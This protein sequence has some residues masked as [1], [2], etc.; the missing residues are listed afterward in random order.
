MLA[1]RYRCLAK[2]M[3]GGPARQ[4]VLANTHRQIR[5]VSEYISISDPDSTYMH[6][7]AYV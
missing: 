4:E 6:V 3:L 5:E 2:A 7:C 1:R